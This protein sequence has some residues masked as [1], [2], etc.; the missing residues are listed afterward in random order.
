MEDQL[1]QSAAE[2]RIGSS[3]E[4]SQVED[5]GQKQ[6]WQTPQVSYYGSVKLATKGAGVNPGDANL[7][8]S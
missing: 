1:N 5:G 6:V 4:L 8:I 3:H 7:N 2:K